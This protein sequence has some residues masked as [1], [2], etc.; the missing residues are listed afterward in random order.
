MKKILTVILLALLSSGS[1]Y[2]GSGYQVLVGAQYGQSE[3]DWDDYTGDWEDSYGLRLGIEDES[4]RMYL[5]YEYSK[6]E[7]FSF[8]NT[9]FESHVLLANFD[10]KTDKHYGF[11]RVFVGGHLGAIYSEWNLA[12]YAPLKDEDDTD[13][14]GGAQIGLIID[15]IDYAYIEAG[16]RFSL[17]SASS[18][19]INP[20]RVQTVYGALNFK[21]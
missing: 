7:D 20:G 1:V 6:S 5:S 14:I 10:A 15:V 4:T 9:D 13:F 2:A 19:S 16:Y 3:G 8:V 11:L 18:D 12:Q 17:T 21:F